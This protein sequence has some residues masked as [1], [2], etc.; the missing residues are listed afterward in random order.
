VRDINPGPPGR[1]PISDRIRP[2]LLS[3]TSTQHRRLFQC[4]SQL[5]RG[6]KIVFPLLYSECRTTNN[7]ID[8]GE[9]NSPHSLWFRRSI[10]LM[11]QIHC[12]HFYYLTVSRFHSIC[13]SGIFYPWFCGLHVPPKSSHLAMSLETLVS[14]VLQFNEYIILLA[15][16]PQAW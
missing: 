14:S 9:T 12:I 11:T 5:K 1:R 15:G 10:M 2:I 6:Y 7:A 4:I 3:T 13:A 8:G 16:N